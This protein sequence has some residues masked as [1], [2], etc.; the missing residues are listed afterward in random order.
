MKTKNKNRISTEGLD[1]RKLKRLPRG[2]FLTKRGETQARNTKVRI[3]ILVDLDVLNFFKERARRSGALPYQTQM[4]IALRAEM[5]DK[6]T[7]GVALTRDERFIQ[8]VA[9]RVKGL[10]SKK[11][12]T[13]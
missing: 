9:R 2:S 6:Q 1:T 12:R 7:V 5:E 10:S 13:A 3:S 11:H 8:A 4:N